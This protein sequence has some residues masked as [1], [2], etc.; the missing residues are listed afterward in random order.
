[1]TTQGDP[2]A[3]LDDDAASDSALPPAPTPPASEAGPPLADWP[4]RA[5]SAVID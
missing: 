4:Y 3:P 1:V 2:A 5:Q